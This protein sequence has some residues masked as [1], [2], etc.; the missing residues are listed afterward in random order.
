MNIQDIMGLMDRGEFSEIS[1]QGNSYGPGENNFAVETQI[2]GLGLTEDFTRALKGRKVLDIGCGRNADLVELLISCNILA[3]G[4]DPLLEREASYLMKRK[5]T[6]I[7]PMQGALPRPSSYYDVVF[8]HS[9]PP[10]ISAFATLGRVAEE[11]ARKYG[12]KED[13]ELLSRRT[14]EGGLILEE[15]IRVLRPGGLMVT[16]PK[17]D[18]LTC[19]ALTLGASDYTI[20]EESCSHLR[21]FNEAARLNCLPLE[22]VPMLEELYTHR[23]I[24][25]KK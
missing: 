21:D 15:A 9:S 19:Q 12:S 11:Q 6:G 17:M 10:L 8:A 1:G 18:R 16:F 13:Q 3:E 22:T 5:I 2:K 4:I 24:L 14:V 7:H 23:T 20:R 25:T